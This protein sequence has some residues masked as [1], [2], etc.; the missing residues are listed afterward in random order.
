MSRR[1]TK[2]VIGGIVA[3]G[4]VATG[5]VVVRQ[6]N[7]TA[8]A[9]TLTA[10]L[11]TVTIQQQDLVTYDETTATLGF[12]ASADVAAPVAGTVTSIVA[13]GTT[14]AAGSVV[15]TIDG[16]P[17]VTL[18]GD[19]PSY[20]DLSAASSDGPDVRQLEMNLVMLGFDPD[21]AI[22]IDEQF[23]AATTAAVTLWETSL[24]LIGDGVVPEGQIAYIPG[25][26][27][28]DTVS[29]AVGSTTQV[30]STLLSA[31]QSERQLLVPAA[32]G[33]GGTV[34]RVI[35]PGTPVT[36][37]TVLLWQN[38]V[39]VIAIEGDQAALPALARDLSLAAV[40]GSDV[41]IFERMLVATGNDPD[42]AI[43]VDDI[44]DEATAAAAVR[45]YSSLGLVPDADPFIPA[46]AFVVVPTGLVAGT[47]LLADISASATAALT[48]DQVAL[49]LTSPPRKVT[50]SAPI[51]DPT[52]AMG[53][54]IDVQFPDGTVQ[55]GTVVAVGNVASTSSDVPGSTPTVS[56]DIQV[57]N[58]P[59]SVESF[60]EVPVTLRVVAESAPAALVVPVG[61]L[62]A[63]AEGGFALETVTGKAADGTDITTLVGVKPGL[64]VDGFVAVTGADIAAGQTVVVPS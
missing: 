17:V 64:F 21:G 35:A 54:V 6:R 11:S 42:Q 29:A 39:P 27:L 51:N 37:G 59:A 5:A 10:P 16:A 25:K 55:P 19:I 30:G 4:L 32:I 40:A 18:I 9:D 14:L 7:D 2:V 36:T 62:V 15:A 47:A 52:F 38:G 12:T 63:L 34:D 41:D 43:V 33:T 56:I 48:S 22:Q 3:A 58:I 24:G 44:Y 53:A 57:D 49:S 20:R 13:E 1:A 45:F 26:L 61:A 46:G 28:V 60:V 31:R 8:A 50:T 23:D